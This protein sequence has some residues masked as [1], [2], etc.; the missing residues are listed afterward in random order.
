MN[1]D[2]DRHRDQV[3]SREALPTRRTVLGLWAFAAPAAALGLS[4]C[5]RVEDLPTR[6]SKFFADDESAKALGALVVAAPSF[7]RDAERLVDAIVGSERAV[8]ATASTADLRKRLRER[9][10]AD[11]REGRFTL[12]DGWLLSVTEARLCALRALR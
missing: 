1:G 8:L 2:R 12:V 3:R 9:H 7:E 4:A 5:G 11:V 10:D 6:L